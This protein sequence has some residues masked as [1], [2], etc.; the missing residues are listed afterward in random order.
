MQD[1][2]ADTC[3][4]L[5]LT[6]TP[7]LDA[8]R[9]AALVDRLGSARACLAAAPRE[10][11][12]L[13]LSRA[14]IAHLRRRRPRELEAGLRWL[15]MPGHLLVTVTDPGYPAALRPIADAPPV[16]FVAGDAA[17]LAAPQVAIVGSRGPTP[18]GRETAY[19]FAARLAAA[20][21]V[22]TSGLATGIDAAAH[23]GALARAAPTVAVCGTGLDIT[24]PAVNAAL[25]AEIAR[26]GALVSEFPPGTPPRRDHFPRRNRLISGLA[27]GVVV[28]EAAYRSGSLITARLAAEQGREVFAVPG[29]VHNPLARGCHRLIRDGA[30]LVE[31][32]EEVLDG[33]QCDLFRCVPEALT[34]GSTDGPD[35]V[36]A[37]DRD[38]KIL[39]NACGFE[40]VD[41]DTLV[42][43]TGFSAAAVASMLVLLELRGEVESSAGGLYCRLPAR[44]AG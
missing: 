11:A 30:R 22:I 29:S 17:V 5:T 39:L 19:E 32:P 41:V 6:T 20:G 31:T 28:V 15:E 9:A 12:G 38:C 33:L 27:L 8:A 42:A 10:L 23:R 43:R 14:S 40:P 1:T 24:Y 34:A 36:G 16:L 37:L 35:P 3:A 7:G 4:W 18:A 21:L 13:G 26:R 2:E 44:P 25:A